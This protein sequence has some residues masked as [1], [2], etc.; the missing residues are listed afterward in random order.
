MT[1]DP[2]KDY[3]AILGVASTAE[4]VVIRAAYKALVQRYHPDRASSSEGDTTEKVAEINE[5]YRILSNQ[6]TRNEYDNLRRAAKQSGRDAFGAADKEQANNP[7]AKK[8]SQGKSKTR[9]NHKSK[10]NYAWLLI[11]GVAIL[12]K[13]SQTNIEYA[14]SYMAPWLIL[15]MIG[16]LALWIFSDNARASW[17]LSA[18]PNRAAYGMTAFLFAGFLI[19]QGAESLIGKHAPQIT[20]QSSRNQ[21]SSQPQSLDPKK[22]AQQIALQPDRNQSSTGRNPL[23]LDPNKNYLVEPPTVVIPE[24]RKGLGAFVDQTQALGSGLKALGAQA[25]GL[26]DVRDQA[27]QDYQRNMDESTSGW[28]TPKGR[29]E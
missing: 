28:Q 13:A 23:N 27:L 2:Q 24:W 19:Q 5:A 6:E 14:G 18:W 16:A 8:T 9:P 15:G 20:P 29:A 26:T 17:T 22:L 25:L 21:S 12:W 7:T 11:L 10:G 4:D 3:Y 1:I